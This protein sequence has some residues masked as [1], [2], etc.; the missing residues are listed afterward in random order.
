MADRLYTSLKADEYINGL[1][2]VTNLDKAILARLAFSYSITQTGAEVPVSTN[3]AGGEMKRTSFVG[4]DESFL[5]SLIGIVYQKNDIEEQEL[6][7]NQSIIKNHVDNGAE[8]LWNLFHQNGED[9]N[10]MPNW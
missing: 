10:G 8:M 4:G 2:S 7:S 3:F 6:Y 5:R 9:V 1:R